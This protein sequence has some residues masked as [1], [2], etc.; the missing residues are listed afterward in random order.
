MTGGSGTDVGG[1]S[2]A[3]GADAGPVPTDGAVLIGPNPIGNI[4]GTPDGCAVAS[5][6]AELGPVLLVFVLDQSGSMANGGQQPYRWDP[7]AAALKSFFSDSASTGI[8]ASL[9]FFPNQHTYNRCR[10]ECCLPSTYENPSVPLTALPDPVFTDVINAATPPTWF[11]T[12]T[13]AALQ[14]SVTYAQ[15][16]AAAQPDATVAIVL[17][18]DGEPS[19]CGDKIADSANAV[20]AV[21]ASIPT[22]VIGV[23]SALTGLNAIAQSGGT[24]SAFILSTGDPVETQA[25]F[26]DAINAIRTKSVSCNVQIPAP[27]AGELLDPT[28]VNVNYTL[29]DGST[30]PLGF[31]QTCTNDVGWKYDNAS[32][33]KLIQ[34]CA[35]TCTEVSANAKDLAVE[36]GCVTRAVIF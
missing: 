28:R 9:T 24:G 20:A 32:D 13:L 7:V 5:L 17:V 3:G 2:N 4:Q 18:T 6:T 16:L 11:G 35:G 1:A 19:D 33:P 23:G 25:R 27:P 15:G 21:A 30:V 31:N 26:T 10:L 34:L 12:P 14:G 29:A 22:F 8:S 36:F